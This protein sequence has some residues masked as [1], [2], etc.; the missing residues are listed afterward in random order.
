MGEQGTTVNLGCAASTNFK[1]GGMIARDAA[2]YATPATAA[3][4]AIGVYRGPSFTSSATSA[5]ENINVEGG[6]YRFANGTTTIA[7]DDIGTAFYIEDDQTISLTSGGTMAAGGVTVNV[8][9][10]G[11]WGNLDILS[12]K[13]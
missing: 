12:R 6:I 2:G 13:S 5:A 8:D 9:T 7:I 4:G 1:Q 11:V 3:L 10:V